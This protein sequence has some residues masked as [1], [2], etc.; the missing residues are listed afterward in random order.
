MEECQKWLVGW[1]FT[2]I[3]AIW[4]RRAGHG[5]EADR[6][7]KARGVSA[8]PVAVLLDHINGVWLEVQAGVDLNYTP[9]SAEKPQQ[10]TVG[11]SQAAVLH[12]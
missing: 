9:R 1:F 10:V 3:C 5:Q 8:S 12:K 4:A 2:K 11:Q 6:G 7:I